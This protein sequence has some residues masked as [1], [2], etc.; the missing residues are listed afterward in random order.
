MNGILDLY[1]KEKEKTKKLKEDKKILYGVIDEVKED[2]IKLKKK[3]F[4]L[5]YGNGIYNEYEQL[6]A[7]RKLLEE[8]DND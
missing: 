6:V 4:N 8:I 5:C 3:I 1:N 7:L 2:Y